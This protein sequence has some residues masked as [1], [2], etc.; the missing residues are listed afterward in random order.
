MI[1]FRNTMDQ[2]AK[3][4][5]RNGNRIASIQWHQSISKRVVWCA[6]GLLEV[7]IEDLREIISEL[8]SH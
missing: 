3:D 5:Y 4:V 2:H 6:N 7:S 1:E 8:D